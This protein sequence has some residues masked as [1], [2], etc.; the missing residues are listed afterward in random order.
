MTEIIK[1]Y[2][3]KAPETGNEL[4][5]P[6]PFNLMCPTSIGPSTKVEAFLRPETAQGIFLNF[7]RLLEQNGYKLPFGAA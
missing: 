1:K 7:P 5:D 6:V 4:T 2:A 3:I